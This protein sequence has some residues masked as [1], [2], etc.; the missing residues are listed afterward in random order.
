M[1]LIKGTLDPFFETGTEG[2]CWCIYEDGKTGY[3]GLELLKPG[4]YLT[5]F[6]PADLDRILWEGEV[7]FDY[8]SNLT[9]IPSNPQYS[10]QAIDGYWVNG[11]QIDVDPKIW[12]MWFN[13]MYPAELI[14]HDIA[15]FPTR[16]KP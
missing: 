9:M 5:V 2:I 13:G 7:D 4:D 11:I 10:L 14:K 12:M 16:P 6:D 1:S 3:E 15:Q 8:K